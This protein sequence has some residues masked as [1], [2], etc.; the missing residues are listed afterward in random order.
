MFFNTK[1]H[2]IIF[3]SR[4]EELNGIDLDWE[5]LTTREHYISY[6]LLIRQLSSAL[7]REGLLL[8]IA[9][10]TKQFFPK[11]VYENVDRVNLM[12]YDMIS[13]HTDHHASYD[14]GKFDFIVRKTNASFRKLIF[15]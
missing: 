11:E 3:G 4:K 2:I 7:H 1:L 13:L 15:Y 5:G 10:H 12:S 6:I 8:S 14:K 9:I